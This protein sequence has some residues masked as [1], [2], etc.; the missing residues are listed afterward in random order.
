MPLGGLIRDIG[1]N[2]GGI[3]KGGL[4]GLVTGGPVGGIVGALGGA[5]GGGRGGRGGGG[6][7]TPPGPVLGPVGPA[8][9]TA[10]GQGLPALPGGIGPSLG[11]ALGGAIGGGIAGPV[12]GAIGQGIGSA[13]GAGIPTLPSRP[14]QT[15]VQQFDPTMALLFAGRRGGQQRDLILAAM[16]GEPLTITKQPMVEQRLK[17][18]PGYVI[19]TLPAAFG[20]GKTAML[21]P[22]ARKAGLYK[23]R[24]K[25]VISY[26][27]GQA[28]KRAARAKNKVKKLAQSSGYSVQVK[29]SARRT[30]AKT[31]R[32]R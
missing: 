30:P 22:L 6:R 9:I 31:T 25:P 24:K 12:G 17:A 19:V 1:R 14:M 2:L 13:L 18:P 15:S 32:K 11:G 27:E 10:G 28:I 5:L 8:P 3:V 7:G 16:S 21:K 26:A 23:P 29:G 4:T 20:G